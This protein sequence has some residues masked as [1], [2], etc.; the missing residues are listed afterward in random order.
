M[1][2]FS[3]LLYSD[4]LDESAHSWLEKNVYFPREVSPN[5]PG[6][7]NLDSQPWMKEILDSVM[8]PRVKEINLVF[9]AQTGKTTILLLSYLLLSRFNPK[10]CLIGLSTDPLAQR[11]VKRRLLPLLKAN[12]WW[13][14]QL[15]PE[16]QG[17]ESM[18]LFPSMDTFYTGARTADKL[19]S[20]ACGILL[21]D[22]VSKWQKGSLREA[23]PYLLVK[24]RTKSF[25]N[26][27]II[28]SSTPS[29]TDEIFW[30]EYLHSSQSHF[31]MPCPHCKE[32]FE[33]LFTPETLKWEAGNLETIHK[34]AH[35]ICPHCNG[36]ITNE[37]KIDV[38]KKGEWRK[39]KENHSKG[40]YGFH[41]NSIYSPFVTFG[42]IATEFIKAQNSIIKSEALRNFDNSWKALPFQEVGQ[43]TNSEDIKNIIDNTRF[44]GEIPE[45]TLYLVLGGDAGQNQSHYVVSAICEDGSIKLVDW[46]TI[47]SYSSA[48]GHYGYSSLINDL[49][50]FDKNNNAWKIDIAYLDSGYSTNE[51][52]EECARDIFGKINP[53]K[54]STHKGVWSESVV[55]S[56]GDLPLFTYSDY[57]LKM[58]LHNLILD[59]VISLPADADSDLIKGLEGQQIILNK[60]GKREW[61][62]LKEDHYN[63]CLK[64]CVFSTWINPI[65][66][67]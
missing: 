26:Y 17:Q 52:Y 38:M 40:H 36:K 59:K 33:F 7:L 35:Y 43:S 20:M 30:Q 10:P 34:T 62:D 56:H 53:T 61:K 21:L 58:T 50:Y 55:K 5:A 25:S 6:F 39:T 47:L 44:K 46:G 32:Y 42:D 2:D 65:S 45:D 63:D 57:S 27:K 29:I 1:N 8:D 54:G 28:S 48:N 60:S 18:I 49:T 51:I 23:H 15:P 64:L 24:E 13:C 12:S 37:M 19:A 9:G 4:T 22:E 16:N 67:N 31:F 11:L 66:K 3:N 14:E 41:L